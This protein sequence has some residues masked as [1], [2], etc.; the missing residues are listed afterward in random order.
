M[1][2]KKGQGCGGTGG[3]GGGK[4]GRG[5][6]RGGRGGG[7]GEDMVKEGLTG[8]IMKPLLII[9]ILQIIIIKNLT[10]LNTDVILLHLPF[11]YR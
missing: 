7:R 5:D 6:E 10:Q 2:K 1:K 8:V 9:V 11:S 4:G 3:H